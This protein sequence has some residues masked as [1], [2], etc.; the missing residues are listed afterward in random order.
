MTSG[1]LVR[2]FLLWTGLGLLLRIAMW[3][4]YPEGSAFPGVLAFGVGFFHDAIMFWLAPGLLALFVLLQPRWVKA[5]FFIVNAVIVI[6]FVAEAFFWLEFESRLDRLVFHYLAYPKEV[7]IF[8]EDQFFLSLVLVPFL[9][10]VWLL[11]RLVGYPDPEQTQRLPAFACLGLAT[12][13][14]R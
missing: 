4:Y 3:I 1:F 7:I 2:W 14:R 10:V 8:L 12:A 11:C 13:G 9:A 5:G 6:V